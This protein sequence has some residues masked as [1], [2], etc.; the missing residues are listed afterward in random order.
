MKRLLSTVCVLGLL[1]FAAAQ[2]ALADPEMEL[3]SGSDVILWDGT[4]L[5]CYNGS[6]VACTV[7]GATETTASG[8]GA[9][10][11][12]IKA[13][14]FN[15]WILNTSTGDS[16]S[17]T[18]SGTGVCEDQNDV[19]TLASGN[20]NLETFF[21]DTGFAPVGAAGLMLTESASDL[22]GTTASPGTAT[23]T[24]YAY[25]GALG[26]SS[27]GAPSLPGA[28]GPLSLTGHGAVALSAG[29][30]NT[31]APTAPYDLTAEFTLTPGPG[32]YNVTE[33]IAT[34]PEPTNAILLGSLLLL[35][36][37]AV[38]KRLRKA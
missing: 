7:F 34:V 13:G 1:G 6:F 16:Y 8:G 5:S 23:A 35:G 15:G 19:N 33:T 2:M 21:G 27:T 24:A 31:T 28:W 36:A 12:T 14:N 20:A 18:C 11:V 32:S 4:T 37:T 3:V 26:F 25:T 10:Q 17:P 29:P 38:R 22:A 9:T 30:V